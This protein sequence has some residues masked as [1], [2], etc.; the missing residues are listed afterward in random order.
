MKLTLVT[1]V[2][3]GLISFV[4]CGDSELQELSARVSNLENAYQSI[5]T[6][7]DRPTPTPIILPAPTLAPAPTP[8]PTPSP[9]PEPTVTPTPRPTLT[10]TPGATVI[11]PSSV[12]VNADDGLNLRAE[13]SIESG[14]LEVLLHQSAV[15]LTGQSQV[16]DD[17]EWVEISQ[18]GWVQAQFLL[19]PE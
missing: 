13:P 5:R 12:T 17:I 1:V 14:V 9:K 7:L 4:G 11:S 6:E 8:N 15:D 19:F 10:P 3:I 18:G 16:I 2:A